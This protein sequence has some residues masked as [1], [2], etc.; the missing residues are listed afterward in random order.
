MVRYIGDRSAVS[1][2]ISCRSL[3][4]SWQSVLRLAQPRSRA[5]RN[6]LE[7]IEGLAGEEPELLPRGQS[8]STS[9]IRHPE[10]RNDPQDAL[11]AFG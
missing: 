2:A 8:W 5:R 4:V 9:E 10:R 7:R 11:V 6:P 3:T 1:L